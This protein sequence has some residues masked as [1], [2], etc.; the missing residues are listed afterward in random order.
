[1]ESSRKV[2]IT[3]RRRRR[4]QEQKPKIFLY[5]MSFILLVI[6]GIVAANVGMV[7][8]GVGSAYAVYDS[9][10]QQ[11]PDPTAIE[12]E[13]EDFETTKIFDR[14]GQV[15]LYEIFDPFR[16]DRTYVELNEIPEF[17]REA[18]VILEDKTFYD[19]LGF[20]PEGI[21]RAFYQNLQG[22]EIQGGSSIT[23]QL[24][25][26]ILIDEEERTQLSY[27]RKMKELI[28]AVEITRRFEKDQILEWYFNTNFFNSTDYPFG[29]HVA[30]YYAAENINQHPF[31]ILVISHV[32]DWLVS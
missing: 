23:Q 4:L 12:T 21:G 5:L 25:K 22:G 3:R 19:N 24:I 8:S 18:V 26:N 10:A 30:A 9:F 16:G 27:T 14:T 2:M 31:N 20:D 13:Q 7:L 32:Q 1:M 11:L 6:A 28:L 29:N 17:C 15:L